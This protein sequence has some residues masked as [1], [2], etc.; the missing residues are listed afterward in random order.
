MENEERAPVP[1]MIEQTPED[2]KGWTPED[3]DWLRQ[4]QPEP[5]QRIARRHGRVVWALTMNAGA[6]QQAILLTERFNR[7]N[8]QVMQAMAVTSAAFNNTCLQALRGV[9]KDAQALVNC[10]ED[11]E[12]IAS[13]MQGAK[14]P[15]E[16]MSRGGILL[17]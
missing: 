3:I 10:R 8:R 7:G 1:S 16:K 11:I 6:I 15:G 4:L 12:R 17:N 13:L 14:A 5:L 2:L 9:G